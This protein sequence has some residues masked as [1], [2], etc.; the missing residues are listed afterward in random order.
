M[1]RDVPVDT[2]DRLGLAFL[3]VG[4]DGTVRYAS[5]AAARRLGG[6]AEDVVSRPLPDEGVEVAAEEPLANGERFLLLAGDEEE[7]REEH[8]EALALVGHVRHDINN[9]LMGALGLLELLLGRD[10]LDEAVRQR[11]ETVVHETQRIREQVKVL[12]KL[13]QSDRP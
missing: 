3:V 4:V 13:R 9:P 10:D 8:R 5:D 6:G 1:M 12:G 2:L 7:L 11:L